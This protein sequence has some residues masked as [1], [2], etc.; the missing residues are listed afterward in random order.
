MSVLARVA[1]AVLGLLEP[2]AHGARW[3]VVQRLRLLVDGGA[4]QL[5]ILYGWRQLA[6]RPHEPW[7]HFHA[8]RAA[9]ARGLDDQA[10]VRFAHAAALGPDE[11]TFRFALGYSLRQE[12]HLASAAR[13]YRLALREIP[14]EPKILFN[15]GVVERERKRHGSAQSCFERVVFHWPRDVRSLYTLGVCA[16]ENGDHPQARASLGKAL[17]RDPRHH[18]SK[19]QLALID[20]REERVDDGRAAL[21]ATLALK[22]NYGPAHYALGRSLAVDDPP[23]AWHHFRESLLADPPVLRAHL[24]L[25]RLHHEGGRLREARAEYLLYARHYPHKRREWIAARVAEIDHTVGRP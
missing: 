16:F 4:S 1:A 13:E 8:G 14:D 22:R 19:Y 7:L 23:R 18:K 9:Q 15:L 25:A 3:V 5:A 21:Q 20:L 24:D 12:G 6:R 2:I 11:A 10:R 17:A